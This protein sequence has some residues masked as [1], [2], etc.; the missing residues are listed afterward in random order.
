MVEHIEADFDH[1][2]GTGTVRLIHLV[3]QVIKQP[4]SFGDSKSGRKGM[5]KLSGTLLW[6]TLK[7]PGVHQFALSLLYHVSIFK[8]FVHLVTS[9]STSNLSPAAPAAGTTLSRLL[10]RSPRNEMS[11]LASAWYFPLS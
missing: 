8:S 2:P 5:S 11:R 3:K 4:L 6:L 1:V 10:T 7:N 9:A